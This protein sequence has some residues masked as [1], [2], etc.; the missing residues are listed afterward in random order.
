[1]TDTE[2][3]AALLADI[4]ENPADDVPRWAYAD[5]LAESGDADRAEFI[6]VQMRLAGL[7]PG[8]EGVDHKD[9]RFCAEGGPE[10]LLRQQ[11][12]LRRR[13]RLW[14]GGRFNIIPCNAP[15]DACGE[16]VSF[17]RGFVRAVRCPQC[18]WIDHGAAL[19]KAH[20]VER[21]ELTDRQPGLLP[22]SAAA[23]REKDD[24]CWQESPPEAAYVAL[25][26]IRPAIFNLLPP[27]PYSYDDGVWH[28]RH[29]GTAAEAID[30]L[31]DA[32][33][34]HARRPV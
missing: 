16:G 6:H 8:C 27:R 1:M 14:S 31:S 32:M 7:P 17:R 2:T 9:C 28:I 23:G 5:W 34:R 22:A 4:I 26:A 12:L 15:W 11:G 19:C 21:A 10:L 13:G 29:F 33:I 20:P 24:W 3:G 18:R 30:A 25:N